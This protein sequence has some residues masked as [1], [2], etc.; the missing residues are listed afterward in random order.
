MTAEKNFK[1]LVRAR[2]RRT[3]ESYASARRELLRKRSEDEMPETQK[4]EQEDLVEVRATGIRVPAGGDAP[5]LVLMD[6][7]DRE[8]LIAIGP[9]EATSI[10]FA[11]QAV[12]V[13]RPMTHDALKQTVDALGAEVLR[14]VVGFL[15]DSNTFTADVVLGTPGG[16][17]HLD[18]R[19]SDSVALVVRYQP[20]PPILV[21]RRLVATPPAPLVQPWPTG[22]RV[23]CSSGHW[24]P[25]EEFTVVEAGT[26]GADLI[27]ADLVC[28]S[29]QER[30]HVTLQAPPPEAA[31]PEVSD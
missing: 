10:A 27:E 15:A 14:V 8:L 24:M 30:R 7:E 21:P 28:P 4:S 29:C 9:A 12:E 16:E 2:S 18:W 3:G 11:L 19:L 6:E 22:A 25:V 20:P 31:N 13:K 23:R 1:R 17:R 26:S 5:F